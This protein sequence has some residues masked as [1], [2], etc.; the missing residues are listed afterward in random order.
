MKNRYSRPFQRTRGV[1]RL[2]A[3]T[4]E[5]LWNGGSKDL[6][7]MPSSTMDDNEVK[8]ELVKFLDNQWDPGISQD[9]D[10]SQSIP[11]NLDRENPNFGKVVPVKELREVCTLALLQV[12]KGNKRE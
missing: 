9:V 11:T 2:L 5:S 3:L 12:Q 4:I 7:S 8:N 6:L 1:L 10:G